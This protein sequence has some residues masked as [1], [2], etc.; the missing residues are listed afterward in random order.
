M[1]WYRSDQFNSPIIRYRERK[2][3]YASQ[4]TLYVGRVSFGSKDAAFG[5]LRSGDVSL[6][7]ENVSLEDAGEYN[8]YVSSDQDHDK[9]VV[10]LIVKG[11]CD[12][13]WT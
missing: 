12:E 11:K 5:G 3:D 6:K 10:S 7:L 1:H 13:K 4:N 9:A 8:C 2:F